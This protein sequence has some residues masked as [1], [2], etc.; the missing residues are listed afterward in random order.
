MKTIDHIQ[1]VF[2]RQ[3]SYPSRMGMTSLLLLRL[4]GWPLK[5]ML[6]LAIAAI[7]II[8]GLIAFGID[9]LKKGIWGK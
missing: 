1:T 9:C 2:L 3:P 6:K 7:V 4:I 5:L 8:A